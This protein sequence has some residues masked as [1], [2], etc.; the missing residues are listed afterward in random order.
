MKNIKENIRQILIDLIPTIEDDDR[1]S[2]DY[3]D[4]DAGVQVTF[5]T[6]KKFDVLEFQTGDN[7]FWGPC[8]HYPIWSVIYLYRDS[9]AGYLAEEV[10]AQ[11][12][13]QLA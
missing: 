8:Y 6:S 9:D 10:E 7:S 1:A 3:D 2:D 4:N 12:F 5:A 11:I 13:E